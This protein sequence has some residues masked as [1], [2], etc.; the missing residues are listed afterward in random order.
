MNS[1]IYYWK[2][3][4]IDGKKKFVHKVCQGNYVFADYLDKV[5]LLDVDP[6]VRK[7]EE[8]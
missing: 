2:Q 8:L 4:F 5:E 6:V 1:R 3:V 7:M